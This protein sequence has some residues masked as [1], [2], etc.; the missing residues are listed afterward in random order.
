MAVTDAG[1]L[2]QDLKLALDRVEFARA[3]GVDPDSWQ[4]KL[5][6]STTDRVL[7][8]CS[9]QSGKSTI[10]AVI[11]LHRA[12][13]Y[14]NSLVLVF[15]PSQD[16]SREFFVKVGRMYRAL[17]E[18]LP[19]DSFRK[20]GM[21]LKNG[22]R[23]EARPGSERSSRGPTADLVVVD[24]AAQIDDELYF[25]LRPMLAVSGG[26]L[27]L[28]STPKGKRGI[29]YEA[30]SNGKG[31]ERYEVPA[32]EC[33]RISA[34]FLEEERRSLPERVFRQ[35][36]MCSFEETED[37]VFGYEVVQGAITDEVAPLFAGKLS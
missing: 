31:W 24:E 33:P 36:Y 27:M 4:E 28:L 20:F 21:E 32:T 11:A 8:N 12:V 23:V 16:Q 35:E 14:P 26:D 1:A 34:E 13:Y 6:R 30:W 2:A 5:L 22:S 18:A 17:G 25:A 37:S 3:V 7:L 10:T 19:A 29:F 9:R 15:G